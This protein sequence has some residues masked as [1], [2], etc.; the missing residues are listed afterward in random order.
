[1][2]QLFFSF[3]LKIKEKKDIL[4]TLAY[5]ELYKIDKYIREGKYEN[6]I[7]F[8]AK[9]NDKKRIWLK[10]KGEML[11]SSYGGYTLQKF[12]YNNSEEIYPNSTGEIYERILDKLQ[13]TLLRRENLQQEWR[14]KLN[15]MNLIWK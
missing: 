6:S 3:Y 5:H 15:L 1:M 8:F 12:F 2:L 4:H 11:Q 9:N 7:D 14:K 13:A 10:K